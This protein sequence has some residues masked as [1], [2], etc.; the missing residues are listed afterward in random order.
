MRGSA[1][2]TLRVTQPGTYTLQLTGECD[3]RTTS[4]RIDYRPCL[5]IPN[6]ITVNNDGRNDRFQ[7]QG[8]PSGS[9]SLEI[10]DRWGRKVYET[11]TYHNDWG[12]AAA[13]GVY[14]YLLHRSGGAASYKGWLEV[15][16]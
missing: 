8:L 7:I 9:W 2:A 3:A 16:R 14:Y 15:V 6:I 12:E 5:T 4:R 11:T 1:G 13:S 10:Y